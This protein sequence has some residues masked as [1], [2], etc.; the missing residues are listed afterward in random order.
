[1]S[2]EKH[3]YESGP[4]TDPNAWRQP[5]IDQMAED[6]RTAY[7]EGVAEQMYPDDPAR[8]ALVVEG[9]RSLS[10]P[11]DRPQEMPTPQQM[12]GAIGAA[13]PGLYAQNRFF[14]ISG[15]SEPIPGAQVKVEILDFFALHQSTWKMD[16]FGMAAG[17]SLVLHRN[18]GGTTILD[19]PVSNAFLEFLR[20]YGFIR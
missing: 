16:I 12:R 20:P 3:P 4:D 14:I 11:A 7:F 18:A 2:D 13:V 15:P 17:T 10:H 1:M 9:L 19:T 5:P 8:Q 6:G